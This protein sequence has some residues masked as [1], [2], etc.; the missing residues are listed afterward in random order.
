MDARFQYALS[1]GIEAER[2]QDFLDLGSR[3]L[4]ELGGNVE[5]PLD[6]AIYHVSRGYETL[7][8]PITENE[9]RWI[10]SFFEE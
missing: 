6:V 9:Q 8:T 2:V 10:D 7:S 5:S 4:E 1:F 3:V